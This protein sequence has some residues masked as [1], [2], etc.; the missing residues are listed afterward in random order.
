LNQIEAAADNRGSTGGAELPACE[1]SM[2]IT[3][4]MEPANAGAGPQGDVLLEEHVGTINTL[5]MDSIR[6]AKA[7]ATCIGQLGETLTAAQPLIRQPDR[8]K[9][10]RSTVCIPDSVS[11]ALIEIAAAPQMRAIDLSPAHELTRNEVRELGASLCEI[12]RSWATEAR[13]D[14]EAE[15]IRTPQTV[16][17]ENSEALAASAVPESPMQY[18][19]ASGLSAS[20]RA[21]RAAELL[22]RTP[23]LEEGEAAV[24]SARINRL[25]LPIAIDLRDRFP[26]L[27]SQVLLG[28]LELTQAALEAKQQ[29]VDHGF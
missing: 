25:Y 9:R 28:E 6:L 29:T 14:K 1:G 5:W 27:F 4:I 2:S 3:A 23:N 19:Q 12:Y 10:L 21:A 26:Q 22:G 18:L 15:Q 20:Q 7:L 8:A 13:A 16:R 11:K 24:K 17:G